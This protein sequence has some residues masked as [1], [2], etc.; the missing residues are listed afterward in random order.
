MLDSWDDTYKILSL[1]PRG[2][3]SDQRNKEVKQKFMIAMVKEVSG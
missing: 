2:L 3:Q 1:F